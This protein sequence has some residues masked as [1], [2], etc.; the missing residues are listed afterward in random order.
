VQAAAL[1]AAADLPAAH[2]VLLHALEGAPQAAAQV[3][4]PARFDQLFGGDR[5]VSYDRPW[6]E[7]DANLLAIELAD[8]ARAVTTGAAPETDGAQGL[9]SLAIAYGFLEAD[10]LG[11]TVT[12]NELMRGA[13]T[14]YQ[15][16][17]ERESFA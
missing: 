11:R 9:R 2:H 15:D 14:P 13:A 12:V 4:G 8:F 10:E 7:T 17:I 16:A 6:A 1:C 5:R 3:F